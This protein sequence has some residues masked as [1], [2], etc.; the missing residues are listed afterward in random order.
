MR[1]RLLLANLSKGADNGD[2]V[3][4]LLLVLMV[5]LLQQGFPHFNPHAVAQVSE[6]LLLVQDQV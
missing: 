3:V 1:V 2:E 5:V 6:Q 4:P